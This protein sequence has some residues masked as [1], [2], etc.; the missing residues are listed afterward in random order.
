MTLGR[1]Y[2]QD[3]LESIHQ[4]WL[5]FAGFRQ[6]LDFNSN[7]PPL[8]FSL[9]GTLN[10]FTDD[11]VRVLLLGRLV[12][13][14]SSIAQLF[15]I[16]R[17]AR[18]AYGARAGR[19]AAIVYALS[20]TFIEWSV[21]MRTDAL[22]VPLWL[23]AFL[24]AIRE[25]AARARSRLFAVGLLMGLA[26]WTNQKVVYHGAPLAIFVLL[27]GPRRAWGWRDLWLPAFGFLLP[28]AWVLG[29]AALEGSLDAMIAHNFVGA[30]GLTASDPYASWRPVTMRHTLARDTGFVLLGAL[31]L[32]WALGWWRASTR[33]QRL[34][35]ASALWIAAS[36]FFTPGPF[37]YYLL[38]VFPMI[39]V[40]AGGF[41]DAQRLAPDASG[42]R[43]AIVAA[44][45]VL[46][47][48][49]PVVRLAKFAPPT[50]GFQKEVI[51]L[52][53]RITD[54]GTPVFDGVGALVQ[55]PDAYG[56]HWILWADE[57]RRYAQGD[58]PPLV[59]TLRAGGARLVLQTYR[60]ER[61]P[62]SD[63]AAL[64]HQFPRLWGPLRVAGYDSGDARVGPEAHSFELWY[65]GMY[66]VVP[67]GTEIDGAPAVGPVRLRAGR[68]EARLPGS[69]ARVILRDAAWR[70]RAT[71]PPPPRDRR[72]FGPYGYAF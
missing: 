45:V 21:E 25:D 3:E 54:P 46:Y 64:F 1:Y 59:A 47:A 2:G 37:H 5:R 35:T 68:H 22:V 19:W 7:H 66:D 57:L 36:F 8:F 48:V 9:L 13:L 16:H 15:L 12:T 30:A 38:S 32:A 23:G 29:A 27:G 34:I 72:F 51:G 31:S 56:F 44:L 39:A 6:F 60:I 61:L 24:L 18:E 50:N 63:L 71:L 14:A 40:T 11:P 41:L 52:A 70:E 43:R 55:R 4:G 69:P 65:D 10:H 20:A 53:A 33:T 17:I 26:F 67:E 58:L 49:P 42:A 28:A 62:K